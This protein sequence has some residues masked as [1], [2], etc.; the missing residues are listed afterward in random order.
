MSLARYYEDMSYYSKQCPSKVNLT[1]SVGGRSRET[2][3]H[4]ISSVFCRASL[5]D[6]IEVAFLPSS[7][8][9]TD[10]I[11]CNE[12]EKAI[13]LSLDGIQYNFSVSIVGELSRQLSLTSELEKVQEVLCSEHNLLLRTAQLFYARVVSAG[14]LDVQQ[15]PHHIV[16]RLIKEIPLE[17]GLG[18]GSSNAAELLK[19]LFSFHALEDDNLLKELALEIGNDVYPCL[20]SEPVYFDGTTLTHARRLVDMVS[21]R[22]FA[23]LLK[24]K[25]GSSTA[26]A[27]RMLGRGIGE[28][29]SDK[30]AEVLSEL[31][32]EQSLESL[33]GKIK[34]FEDINMLCL[35]DFLEPVEKML[36]EVRDARLALQ[37]AG[38]KA[39]LLTGSG[40]ALYGIFETPEASKQALAFLRADLGFEWFIKEIQIY[41]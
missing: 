18:G 14:L 21:D 25:R 23:L 16:M 32:R 38:A 33:L 34:T 27:F 39:A 13:E 4:A 31:E 35:N 40:S 1:L 7:D 3:L 30:D 8:P 41:L 5:S 9:G 15:K 10:S 19:I 11:S 22:F 29:G 26:E 24:P 12:N 2:G 17:A 6:L 20:F 37:N 28:E 36:P